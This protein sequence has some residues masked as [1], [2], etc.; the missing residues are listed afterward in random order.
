MAC[1]PNYYSTHHQG[2]GLP[3]FTRTGP[4][5]VYPDFSRPPPNLFGVPP[6]SMPPP[7]IGFTKPPPMMRGPTHDRQGRPFLTAAQAGWFVNKRKAQENQ[8]LRPSKKAKI[9]DTVVLDMEKKKE[10][11]KKTLSRAEEKQKWAEWREAQKTKSE[12]DKRQKKNLAIVNSEEEEVKVV[13]SKREPGSLNRDRHVRTNLQAVHSRPLGSRTLWALYKLGLW[14]TNKERLQPRQRTTS[15]EAVLRNLNMENAAESALDQLYPSR[16]TN[17]KCPQ[18]CLYFPHAEKEAFLDHTAV[19]FQANM[20]KKRQAKEMKG[21]PWYPSKEDLLMEGVA[22]LNRVKM[23]EEEAKQ[24]KEEKK[25]PTVKLEATE[26]RE[27]HY[28]WEEFDQKTI[29]EDD[30]N[31]I[32][33]NDFDVMVNAVLEDGKLFHPI[34]AL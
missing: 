13:K 31:D 16:K 22:H 17:Y 12:E 19:H 15:L 7:R 6:P 34:C 3:L 18:C 4:T 21:R 5:M 10:E 20:Q 25:L 32:F 14:K 9:S 8:C 26:L 29:Y 23:L 11:P 24:K 1:F 2:M 33:F 27:C 30:E 28:C